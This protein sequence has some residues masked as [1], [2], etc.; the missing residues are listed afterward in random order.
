M[1]KFTQN[2]IHLFGDFLKRFYRQVY[3]SNTDIN[4]PYCDFIIRYEN[5]NDDFTL[6]LQKIGVKQKSPLPMCNKT[7][8]KKEYHKYF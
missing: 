6:L 1:F 2:K 5:L 4:S 8:G 3:T 7:V